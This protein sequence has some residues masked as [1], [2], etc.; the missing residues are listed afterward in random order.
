MNRTTHKAIKTEKA[1]NPVGPYNQATIHN[2]IIYVSGQVPI[3]PQTGKLI[4]GDIV[5]A[6]EQVMN[7]IK[8]ILNEAESSLDKILKC[9]I[10]VKDLGQFAKIN[11]TYGKF[12]TAPFPARETVQVAKLPLDADIEISVIAYV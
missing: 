2:G 6:T 10:F 7:N 9:S 11:D 8:A 4:A 1:P 5:K 3:D 12:L